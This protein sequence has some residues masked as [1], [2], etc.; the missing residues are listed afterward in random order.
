MNCQY[1][2]PH[3]ILACACILF[4]DL[5][6]SGLLPFPKSS[7]SVAT[8]LKKPVLPGK[9]DFHARPF[10]KAEPENKETKPISPVSKAP[11][12]LPKPVSQG[13]TRF[14]SYLFRIYC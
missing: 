13:R 4:S 9:P 2:L 11:P 10:K 6:S 3:N 1:N 14:K 7:A 12:S 5:Q 8:S